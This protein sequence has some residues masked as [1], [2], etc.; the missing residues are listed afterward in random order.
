MKLW[1]GEMMNMAR[2]QINRWTDKKNEHKASVQQTWDNKATIMK[3]AFQ[4]WKSSA[5][6]GSKTI[7]D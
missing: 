6:Y 5:G 1:T 4:R 2:V 7:E 3:E